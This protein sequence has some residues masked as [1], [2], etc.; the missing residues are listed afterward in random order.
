MVTISERAH[1]W[2]APL[3]TQQGEVA[4]LRLYVKSGGCSG[5]SYGMEIEEQPA[6]TDDEVID[7]GRGIRV[8][9]DSTSAQYLEGAE[10]DYV[11]ALM[12][13]GF[14]IQ[15][16]NATRTCGCGHSFQ[17]ADEAGQPKGCTL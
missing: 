10:V 4:M 5:F 6:A 13:G 2:L 16:P 7:A 17:T 15:N 1:E 14:T 3:L 9:I 12:G 11:D 8:L